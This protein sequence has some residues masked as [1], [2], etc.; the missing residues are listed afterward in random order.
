MHLHADPHAC[1]RSPTT[2]PRKISHNK[3]ISSS[4]SGSSGSGSSGVVED[5][6]VEGEDASSR[7]RRKILERIKRGI[8]DNAGRTDLAEGEQRMLEHMQLYV[9]QPEG[10]FQWPAGDPRNDAAS[11]SVGPGVPVRVRGKKGG[12]PEGPEGR[13]AGGA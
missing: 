5:D 12:K 13:A 3:N 10:D 7:V 2:R 9:N 4:S 1:A 8:A 11:P 6:V